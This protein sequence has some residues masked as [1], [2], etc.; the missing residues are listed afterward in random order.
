MS[1]YQNIESRIKLKTLVMVLYLLV[2]VPLIIYGLLIPTDYIFLQELNLLN[3]YNN[4]NVI[5]ITSVMLFTGFGL[6]YFAF[7]Y[8]KERQCL[9]DE[10]LLTDEE[11][12]I[13]TDFFSS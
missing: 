2:G 6:I 3:V 1:I 7:L 11:K 10:F 5:L 4:F 12:K 9:K 13:L 8:N